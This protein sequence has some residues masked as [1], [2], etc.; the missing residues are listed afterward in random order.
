M[1]FDNIFVKVEPRGIEGDDSG[2]AADRIACHL[3]PKVADCPRSEVAYAESARDSRRQHERT[4][5][6]VHLPLDAIEPLRD[7][8][9]VVVYVHEDPAGCNA[10]SSHDQQQRS[11]HGRLSPYQAARPR[12]PSRAT[13]E[14]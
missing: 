8:L 6:F 14:S 10:E 2:D 9:S 4:H 7:I 11:I 5:R 1:S 3:P 13:L 12:D